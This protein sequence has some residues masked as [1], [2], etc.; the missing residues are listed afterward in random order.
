MSFFGYS[1]ACIDLHMALVEDLRL[2]DTVVTGCSVVVGVAK[3]NTV[4]G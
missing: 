1:F 3:D 4:L 2:V